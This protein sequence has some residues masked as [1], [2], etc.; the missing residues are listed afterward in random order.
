MC[1]AFSCIVLEAGDIYWQ[2]GLDSHEDIIDKFKLNKYDKIEDGL[3]RIEITP[4]NDDYLS[5]NGKWKFNFDT[6]KPKWWNNK[7]R[8]LCYKELEKWKDKV[9]SSF[10]LEEA[11]NPINP[12]EI[13]PPKI[14]KKHIKLLREWDSAWDSARNSVWDSV[15][16]YIGSLFPNIKK[17]KYT[18]NIKVKGYPFQ[19]AVDLWKMGL[20]P[21]YDGK[22]W[23]LH[24]KNGIEW[25]GKL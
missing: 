5:P 16:A 7:Y 12:F 21:S 3:C 18:E 20:V 4:E 14:T 9:Y 11:K 23:R 24:S 13:E 1:Q 19:S 2:A 8:E 6:P 25:E 17:W 22:V 10:K 15:W